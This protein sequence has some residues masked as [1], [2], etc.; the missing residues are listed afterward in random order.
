MD[1]LKFSEGSEQSLNVVLRTLMHQIKILSRPMLL[2]Q[3]PPHCSPP[4]RPPPQWQWLPRQCPM[5]CQW[6]LP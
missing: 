3:R 2:N 4:P 1:G 6:Q 5:Q